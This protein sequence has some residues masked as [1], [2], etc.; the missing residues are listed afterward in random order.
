VRFAD[1]FGTLGKRGGLLGEKEAPAVVLKH[2]GA[3]TAFD[4][5]DPRREVQLPNTARDE[6]NAQKPGAR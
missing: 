2:L 3:V 4:A 5:F 1:Q 6:A